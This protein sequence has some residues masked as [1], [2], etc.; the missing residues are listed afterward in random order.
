MLLN[1]GVREDSWEFLGLQGDQTSPE[2]NQSWIFTGKTDAEAESPILWPHDEMSQLIRKDPD[3][4]EE[5]RQEGK[6]RQRMRWLDGVTDSMNMSLSKL[7]EVVKG[8][9][10]WCAAAHGVTKSW[11]R[12]RDWTTTKG[13]CNVFLKLGVYSFI[14]WCKQIM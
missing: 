2:G 1:C 11:T 5:W 3:S 6:G 7:W 4:G 8:R 13:L 14:F 12:L 10:A 9:E